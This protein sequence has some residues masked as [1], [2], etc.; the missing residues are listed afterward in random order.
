MLSSLD[1]DVAERLSSNEFFQMLLILSLCLAIFLPRL[2]PDCR[3]LFATREYE[4][5]EESRWSTFLLPYQSRFCID[6]RL[7]MSFSGQIINYGQFCSVCKTAKVI[8][9]LSTTADANQIPIRRNGQSCQ[10]KSSID[11][12]LHRISAEFIPGRQQDASLFLLKLLDHSHVL[13]YD[14]IAAQLRRNCDHTVIRNYEK[15]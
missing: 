2:S 10:S 1:F 12:D 6:S 4:F 15:I 5:Y 7:Y 13:H 8:G 11:H 14:E 3:F 9:F